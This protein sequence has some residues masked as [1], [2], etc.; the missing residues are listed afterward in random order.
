MKYFTQR[1]ILALT[2]LLCAYAQT[3]VYAQPQRTDSVPLFTGTIFVPEDHG[4][5]GQA[6]PSVEIW[7]VM[8]MTPDLERNILLAPDMPGMILSQETGMA[9]TPNVTIENGN[10]EFYN[11][12]TE[13]PLTLY[14][15]PTG[16]ADPP[17]TINF[18]VPGVAT[19]LP[20]HMPDLILLC[21]QC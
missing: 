4:V 12:P 15:W 19:G 10:F 16:P 14:V 9:V 11:V 21:E 3:P 1:T 18:Q 6:N 5:P 7:E 17:A 8:P 13:E 2:I 20:V